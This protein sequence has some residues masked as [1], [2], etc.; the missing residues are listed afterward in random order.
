MSKHTHDKSKVALSVPWHQVLASKRVWALLI[1][2]IGYASMSL[3]MITYLPKYMSRVLKFSVEYNGYLTS[4]VFLSM[5]VSGNIFSWIADYLISKRGISTTLMRKSFSVVSLSGSGIFL[6]AASY[7]RCDRVLAVMLFVLS[8]TTMGAA[9]PSLM[10]NSLDLSPN[11]AGT[12]TGVTNGAAT[13]SGI[14]MPIIIGNLTPSQG[15]GEWNVVYWM[16]MGIGG[17]CNMIFLLFGSGE[18]QHWND[19]NFNKIE[20]SI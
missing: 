3:T 12:L 16:L 10:V 5:W 20:L 7:A 17:I 4:M 14:I 9:F 18:V 13:C 2:L 19:P 6:L 11:Y 1:G 8:L 15:L